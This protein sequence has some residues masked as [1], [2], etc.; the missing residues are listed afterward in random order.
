MMFWLGN[1]SGLARRIDR[2]AHV[3]A[4]VLAGAHNATMQRSVALHND[5]V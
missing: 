4:R 3:F 5:H 2:G 1:N